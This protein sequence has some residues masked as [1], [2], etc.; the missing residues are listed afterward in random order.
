M[1]LF[2]LFVLLLVGIAAGYRIV[3]RPLTKE[4]MNKLL[5]EMVAANNPP[6][7]PHVNILYR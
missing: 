1:R 5:E 4:E 3:N 7:R 6:P 2:I